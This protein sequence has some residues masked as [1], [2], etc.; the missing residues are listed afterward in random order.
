MSIDLII[1]Y[2]THEERVSKNQYGRQDLRTNQYLNEYWINDDGSNWQLVLR[3]ISSILASGQVWRSGDL[4]T[5][6]GPKGSSGTEI[7]PGAVRVPAPALFDSNWVLLDEN[8]KGHRIIFSV[9]SIV[10]VFLWLFLW[11]YLTHGQI[12]AKESLKCL[13]YKKRRMCRILYPL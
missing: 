9:T 6:S 13:L 5:P 2:L 3:A 4:Q 7:S 8:R 11:E 10:L 1:H 12:K